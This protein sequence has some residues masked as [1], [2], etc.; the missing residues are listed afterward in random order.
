VAR[1]LSLGI[2]CIVA[3][4]LGSSTLWAS[5]VT[6]TSAT[7]TSTNNVNSV[8]VAAYD[9]LNPSVS[10]KTCH[11]GLC[12]YGL[13]GLTYLDWHSLT[14]SVNCGVQCALNN[15]APADV[16]FTL[17]SDASLDS[18]TRSAPDLTHAWRSP[19][20]DF[21]YI[22][23]TNNTSTTPGITI[24]GGSGSYFSEISFYW[25]SVDPWNTVTI[26]DV[27]NNSVFITGTNLHTQGVCVPSISSCGTTTYNNSD[28]V[29]DF[30]DGGTYSWKSITLASC[31]GTTCM[32]SFEID[33]LQYI[34][35]TS[36]TFP[37][38]RPSP[39]PEPSSL[40]LLGSGIVGLGGLLR[41]RLRS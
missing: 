37:G 29:V 35:T 3:A 6:Y 12:G 39:T 21:G 25:G 27:M 11:G 32:R 5:Y 40:S 26:T 13:S 2:S 1:K 9:P 34:A 36:T 28:V 31:N 18:Y 15:L 23:S 7:Y 24:T 10:S 16:Q 14:T 20:N 33:D 19:A 30:Q 38:P 17:T 8:T 4:F 22:L 41:R